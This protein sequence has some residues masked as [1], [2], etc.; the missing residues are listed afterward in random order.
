M[1]H[2]G[3]GPEPASRPA[4]DTSVALLEARSGGDQVNFGKSAA[5]HEARIL[6][7]NI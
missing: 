5:D 6:S 2:P 7:R 1:T 4:Q 3:T